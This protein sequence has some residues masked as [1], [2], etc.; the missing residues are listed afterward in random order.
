[1][2]YV[3]ATR[4][5]ALHGIT[6]VVS[7]GNHHNN[8]GVNLQLS[9]GDEMSVFAKSPYIISVAACGTNQ[10]PGYRKDD[11]MY[12][13]S[14]RGD[15]HTWNPTITA[16]GMEMGIDRPYGDFGSNLVVDGTSYS[17]PFVCGVIALMLQRNPNLTFDQIRARLQ[18]SATVLPGYTVADQGAGVINPEQAILG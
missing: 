1:M 16:P 12:P 13:L 11:L 7:M 17:T 9:L 10:T 8:S 5:A 4:Q 15:G 14:S 18:Q 3:E 6:T 2:Q